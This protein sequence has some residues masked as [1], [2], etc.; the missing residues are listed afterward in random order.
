MIN[1]IYRNG[2]SKSFYDFL[3]DENKIT[4]NDSLAY[5]V[6]LYPDL[7]ERDK[8]SKNT[9][10]N[11]KNLLLLYLS[12]WVDNKSVNRL[13]SYVA[14]DKEVVTRGKIESDMKVITN[15]NIPAK[16][17][18]GIRYEMELDKNELIYLLLKIRNNIN[19][20]NITK[21]FKVDL[22][23]YGVRDWIRDVINGKTKDNRKIK[24]KILQYITENKSM[25]ID[26]K[27]EL[28]P[29]FIYKIDNPNPTL[30][31]YENKI[32]GYIEN[33][34]KKYFT[35]R[36]RNILEEKHDIADF[37]LNFISDERYKC[38]P[39]IKEY[40]EYT[41]EQGDAEI[42]ILKYLIFKG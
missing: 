13:M 6:E 21:R 35:D 15:N 40:N 29:S 20:E 23:M 16:I 22:Y 19:I 10:K 8:N 37:I 27:C 38:P 33:N 24:G 12:T 18:N 9:S 30:E 39:Y 26:I 14:D 42:S 5:A 36:Y 11:I 7:P 32:I 17:E 31:T 28:S 41:P 25:S 34:I 4:V 3:Q 1:S 2:V